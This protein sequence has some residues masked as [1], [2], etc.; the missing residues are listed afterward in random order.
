MTPSERGAQNPPYDSD[1]EELERSSAKIP[2]SGPTRAYGGEPERDGGR[3]SALESRLKAFVELACGDVIPGANR[4][5]AWEYDVSVRDMEQAIRSVY[6]REAAE[7]YMLQ[8]K[9]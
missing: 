3:A 4:M 9:G 8:V 6:G 1:A 2:R 7:K 5:R